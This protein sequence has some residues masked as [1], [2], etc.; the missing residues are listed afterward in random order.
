MVMTSNIKKYKRNPLRD[1]A[2]KQINWFSFAK[3][4]ETNGEN[5]KYIESQQNIN[6]KKYF[7]DKVS[8][9]LQSIR[10]QL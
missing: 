10:S 6:K 1:S 4:I 9:E 7:L 2:L 3:A 8:G 5:L